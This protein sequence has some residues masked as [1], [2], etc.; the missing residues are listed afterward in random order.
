MRF[1][2]QLYTQHIRN[3]GIKLNH[4]IRKAICREKNT[5]RS[6]S[7]LFLSNLTA[8]NVDSFK[9]DGLNSRRKS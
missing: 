8:V 3:C 9:A 2:T 4:F 5:A 7:S 1:Y 6:F